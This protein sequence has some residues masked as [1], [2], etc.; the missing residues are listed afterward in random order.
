MRFPTAA[1]TIWGGF[2]K[3]WAIAVGIIV[4]AVAALLA[5]DSLVEGL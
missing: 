2:A 3:R 4:L 5:Y 1:V